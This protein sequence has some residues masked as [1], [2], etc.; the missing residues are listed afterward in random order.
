MQTETA[1]TQ[2]TPQFDAALAFASNLHRTQFRKTT[3]SPYVGHLLGVTAIVLENGGGENEAIAALLHDAV[4]D[5][6]GAATRAEILSRFGS[7]VT[8]IVDGC[9]EDRI[10]RSL[11]HRQRKQKHL[12]SIRNASPSV[13]LVYAAD[14][15]HNGR[16][17]LTGHRRVGEAVW[18]H[19]YGGR[20]EV[21]WYYKSALESFRG[22]VPVVL[23]ED[24]NEVVQNIVALGTHAKI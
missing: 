20:D 1:T 7:S 18:Q 5:Q 19:F 17:V 12:E 6:G 9:T 2:L 21:I 11:A 22:R 13:A 4:E 14:K 10:D 16:T 8:E 3:K 15:L 24:L 23:F